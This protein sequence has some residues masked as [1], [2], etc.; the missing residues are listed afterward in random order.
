M[1]SFRTEIENPIVEK[2][3]IQLEQKIRA[4]KNWKFRFFNLNVLA[5]TDVVPDVFKLHQGCVG[6]PYG[7][8]L[9]FLQL[10]VVF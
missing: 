3:I 5:L 6:L 2:D 9:R 4:F 7:S 10:R 1:Q 8:I